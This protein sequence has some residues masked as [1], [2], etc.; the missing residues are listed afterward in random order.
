[1]RLSAVCGRP[2]EARD[3]QQ[4]RTSQT[5][6]PC[7]LTQQILCKLPDCCYVGVCVCAPSHADE[8]ARLPRPPTRTSSAA[9]PDPQRIKSSCPA[10]RGTRVGDSV[11]LQGFAVELHRPKT[12]PAAARRAR[13]G[14]RRRKG[15]GK[16]K[17]CWGRAGTGSD[18]CRPSWRTSP[19]LPRAP[20]AS[21]RLSH[22]PMFAKRPMLRLPSRGL[23]HRL[24]SK[25]KCEP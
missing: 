20:V 2:Q 23:L 5:C 19:A 15:G 17:R 1:M 25:S 11:P 14:G 6:F 13:T 10:Q 12:S 24:S 16:G 18:A 22:A 4:E 3:G 9:M 21:R 8:I 7:L